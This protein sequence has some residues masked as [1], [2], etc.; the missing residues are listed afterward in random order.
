MVDKSS[1]VL[2][3]L[4][5]WLLI[6]S[7]SAAP[8]Q[9]A[10]NS[11]DW[12]LGGD[13]YTYTFRQ[14]TKYG[15]TV[16]NTDYSVRNLDLISYRPAHITC[17]GVAFHRIFHAGADLYRVG[18]STAG[19]AVRAVADGTVAFVSVGA[20]YP[21]QAIVLRHQV[22]GSSDVY[23][24]YLHLTNVTVSLNQTI[25]KGTVLGNVVFQSH[26]GRYPEFHPDGDDSHLHFE[27]R[28]FE[29]GGTIFPSCSAAG[30][31]GPGYAYPGLPDSY[32]WLNPIDYINQRIP[33]SYLTF[34]PLTLKNSP[35]SLCQEGQDLL[36]NDGFESGTIGDPA[37][38]LEVTS[39]F[40]VPF[41]EMVQSFVVYAGQRSARAGGA[42]QQIIDDEL[43]QN[44]VVPV[45]T[46]TAT[47]EQAIRIIT[48]ETSP[49]P[50]DRFT[51]TLNDGHTNRNLLVGGGIHLDNTS[52]LQ[53]NWYILQINVSNMIVINGQSVNL[54]YSGLSD[55]DNLSTSMVVDEVRFFT[56]CGG[57]QLQGQGEELIWQVTVIPVGP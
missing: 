41:H 51:L 45:G 53:N 54:S 21:G 24:V 40:D 6:A 49:T 29:D 57:T 32:G 15:A 30:K 42:F 3:F 2:L 16:E 33:K 46:N 52:P 8:A 37:P 50:Q 27:I 35:S 20:N 43:L 48:S 9:Q 18:A 22:A 13:G 47:W 31:P 14:N 12:P 25:S 28:S 5:P 38:W 10:A 17:F 39:A 7:I 1:F 36:Q 4:M 56:H 11:W 55:D 19:A 26:L 44:F 34:L 23:S